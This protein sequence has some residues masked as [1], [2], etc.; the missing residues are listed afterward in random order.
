[1]EWEKY[2]VNISWKINISL[3]NLLVYKRKAPLNFLNL[4][5][6]FF[7][8]FYTK[9]ELWSIV[10]LLLFIENVQKWDTILE[11]FTDIKILFFFMVEKVFCSSNFFSF[12]LYQKCVQKLF[13]SH[14]CYFFVCFCFEVGNAS[15]AG[16]DFFLLW[17][18]ST[19]L[20]FFCNFFFAKI[21]VIINVFF[22]FGSVWSWR[23]CYYNNN[24]SEK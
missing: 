6:F 22:C 17:I 16:I 24:I 12:Q 10:L 11:S 14:K 2:L 21:F 23:C 9:I 5:S 7:C 8:C 1:M 19:F 4:I 15:T 20:F 3:K 18:L 13:W